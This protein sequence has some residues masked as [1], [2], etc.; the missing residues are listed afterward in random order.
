MKFLLW[1]SG[2]VTY[3]SHDMNEL[4]TELSRREKAANF[5]PNPDIDVQMKVRQQLL[6]ET[7]PGSAEFELFFF[8][9]EHGYLYSLMKILILHMGKLTLYS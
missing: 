1:V 9:G 7:L 4:L 3:N 5:K 8:S 2:R 6:S